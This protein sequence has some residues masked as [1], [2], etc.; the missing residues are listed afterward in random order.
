MAAESLLLLPDADPS[1][2]S[3]ENVTVDGAR[4]GWRLK[5]RASTSFVNHAL[6]G[7]AS[8]NGTTIPGWGIEKAIDGFLAPSNDA[9]FDP[10]S[11]PCNLDLDLGTAKSFDTVEYVPRVDGVNFNNAFKTYEL[12][13][14]DDGV[15]W[16]SA[17]ASGQFDTGTP[18]NAKIYAISV[19]SQTK[20]YVRLRVLDHWGFGVW[21]GCS[22]LRVFTSRTNLVDGTRTYYSPNLT[23]GAAT[24]L[25]DGRLDAM[26][27][28]GS[29]GWQFDIDFGAVV[30][31]DCFEVWGWYSSWALRYVDLL[32]S[33]DAVTWE[34]VK[35]E[36]SYDG[37]ASPVM[38][39][40]AGVILSTRYV[41][42]EFLGSGPDPITLG[43][44]VLSEMRCFPA[45][46]ASYDTGGPSSEWTHDF[47]QSCTLA[48]VA[49][50]EDCEGAATIRY[51]YGFGASDPPALN[52]TWLT[53]AQLATA[54]NGAT[55]Q[56]LRISVQFNS[57]GAD[58]ATFRGLA[59]IPSDYAQGAGPSTPSLSVADLGNGTGA[60]ATISAGSA[61]AA[62]IVYVASWSPSL[63]DLVFSNGGSRTGNGTVSLALTDG[64]YV[65]YVHSTLNGQTVLSS[66]EVFQ[67]TGSSPAP[68]IHYGLLEAL[69][70]TI[71][72]MV[73]GGTLTGITLAS[74]V[75]RKLP[76]WLDYVNSGAG[77]GEF[78]YPGII[79]CPPPNS[80]TLIP[81]GNNA[82]DW[83]FPCLI[84]IVANDNRTLDA[85][86]N[87]YLRWRQ[88]IIDN[89]IGPEATD[90]TYSIA[91]PSTQFH[92]VDVEP[93]PIVD[94]NRWWG[95]GKY[96]SS[97]VLRFS[98]QR[99]R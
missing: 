67:V 49:T 35:S 36:R 11:F 87:N 30:H 7:T 65:A 78:D 46:Q 17:I 99:V 33:R 18:T 23:G 41:R 53:E 2:A 75:H 40:D 98:T 32:I 13:V 83:S 57:N 5:R 88:K 59:V 21:S 64:V 56:Y 45:S 72:A 43:G 86:E 14:S 76:L 93:G 19:A 62:N 24:A 47:G 20:R 52:G 77:S 4:V 31:I 6:T 73:T 28:G 80:E 79:I 29:F 34:L 22:E 37:S 92:N 12:Y 48:S 69:E 38:V 82:E 51:Q 15:S 10:A 70:T 91:S 16:G 55:G 61:S 9:L 84:V 44:A 71:R 27:H 1:S 66:L 94:Y 25:Y 89:F 90:K 97:F 81:V 39:L 54:L 85:S 96:V 74:I 42:L 8:T 3:L 95:E 68:C 50:R 58:R 26:Y 63:G 60:T